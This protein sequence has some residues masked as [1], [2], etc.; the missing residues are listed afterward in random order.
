MATFNKKTFSNETLNVDGNDY[1]QCTFRTCRLV[2]AGGP[3]PVFKDFNFDNCSFELKDAADRTIAFLNSVGQI[4]G[5]A[6]MVKGLFRG[7]L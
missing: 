7:M 1:N 3:L 6:A 4:Q 5:G 2:Y